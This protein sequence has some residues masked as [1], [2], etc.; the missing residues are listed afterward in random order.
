M[1]TLIAI[2]TCH[3]FRD[4]ADSRARDDKLMEL[5]TA[6]EARGEEI[7]AEYHDIAQNGKATT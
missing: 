5:C 1:K 7:T 3:A 2:A 6:A 4:R